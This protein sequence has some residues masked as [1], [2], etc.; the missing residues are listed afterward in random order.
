MKLIAPQWGGD[1]RPHYAPLERLRAILPAGS[2]IL[3]TSATLSPS[4]LKDICSSLN[5]DLDEAF[6]LNL[7]N[8]SPNS[9]PSVVEMKSA[10]VYAA[11][12]SLLPNPSYAAKGKCRV[13]KQFRRGKIKILVA[14]EAAGMPYHRMAGSMEQD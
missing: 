1:F 4:A 3:A 8:D 10:K 9:T 6:F 11:I 13:M 14:T 7:G 5:L 12:D 2:P